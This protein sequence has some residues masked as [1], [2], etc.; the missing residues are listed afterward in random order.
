MG[1]EFPLKMRYHDDGVHA[2][3]APRAARAG[4]V[5]VEDARVASIGSLCMEGVARNLEAALEAVC[6]PAAFD[7]VTTENPR[8][9]QCRGG[10]SSCGNAVGQ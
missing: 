9:A 8:A 3:N 4:D 10:A 2:R 7:T 5:R 1:D 6:K